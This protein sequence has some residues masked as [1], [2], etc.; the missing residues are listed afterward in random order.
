MVKA[1]TFFYIIISFLIFQNLIEILSDAYNI[2][3]AIRN[4]KPYGFDTLSSFGLIV[5]SYQAIIQGIL[6][7]A[8]IYYLTIKQIQQ[9][10]QQI[11]FANLTDSHI[12]GCKESILNKSLSITPIN[13]PFKTIQRS[14]SLNTYKDIEAST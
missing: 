7:L 12:T 11:Q 3:Y 1:K 9:Q 6:M 14:R 2:L 8:I 13:S 5:G 10:K 4:S